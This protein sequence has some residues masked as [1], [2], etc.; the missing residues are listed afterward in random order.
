MHTHVGVITIAVFIMNAMT[1]LNL[2]N[3]IKRGV[4]RELCGRALKALPCAF[5]HIFTESHS[6][7][8]VLI[9]GTNNVLALL[10]LQRGALEMLQ[11]LLAST[12]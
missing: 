2:S 8:V 4:A 5:Q 3:L 12:E 7:Q 9:S 6:F 10:C 11:Y 1:I